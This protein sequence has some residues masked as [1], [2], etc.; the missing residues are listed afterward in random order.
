MIDESLK[1]NSISPNGLGVG[2]QSDG[3]VVFVYGVLEDE[4]ISYRIIDNHA[5]YCFAI[6]NKIIEKSQFRIEG[7]DNTYLSTS[8]F[9]I[10]TLENEN[11]IKQRMVKD[12]FDSCKIQI[13]YLE[14][15]FSTQNRTKY[16]SKFTFFLTDNL[17]LGV[18]GRKSDEIIEVDSISIIKDEIFSKAKEIEKQ[19]Q[20]S[21]IDPKVIQEII[22]RV[23][24]KGDCVSKILTSSNK[25]DLDIVN[26]IENLAIVL[27]QDDNENN[28]LVLA[29]NSKL[30]LNDEIF[31]MNFDYNID[32]FWQSNLE[33]YTSILKCI[34]TYLNKNSTDNILDYYSGV[35]SIGISLVK[36]IRNINSIKF[37]ENDINS[38]TYLKSNVENNLDG[39]NYQTVHSTASRAS[40]YIKRDS[41]LIVDPPRAGLDKESRKTIKDIKPEIIVYLSCN[42]LTQARDISELLEYYNIVFMKPFNMFPQTLHIEN[43]AILRRKN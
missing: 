11:R 29:S 40:K 42:P 38:S 23:N 34:Q 36:K 24:E 4:T 12:S 16:R 39:I 15:I 1:I 13:P 31:E 30:E 8:P 6:P 41:T 5:K 18:K 20:E 26:R 32:S 7:V 19:L 9:Q 10:T 2:R 35:G 17:K 28:Q 3:K 37:I 21:K 33:V 14:K 43:L 27:L 25:I 22:I